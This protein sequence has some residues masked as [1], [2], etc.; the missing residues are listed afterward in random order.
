MICFIFIEPLSACEI[1]VKIF[2]TDVVIAKFKYL[3]F[4]SLKGSWGWGKIVITVALIYRHWVMMAYSEK[5]S[6]IVDLEKCEV[7]SIKKPMMLLH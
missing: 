3:I 4:A 1:S 7:Y 6:E 5:L 2:I